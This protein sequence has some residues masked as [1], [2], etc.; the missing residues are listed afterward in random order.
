[1]LGNV[2]QHNKNAESMELALKTKPQK[3]IIHKLISNGNSV[4]FMLMNKCQTGL[5]TSETI[6]F[7]NLF[8]A[9]F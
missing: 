4:D 2:H 9:L 5:K 3:I 7:C 1:M 8:L 6:L